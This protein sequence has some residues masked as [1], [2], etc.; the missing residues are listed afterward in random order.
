V[1]PPKKSLN[2]DVLRLFAFP[3]HLPYKQRVIITMILE[4]KA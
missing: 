1:G 4:V 2:T 3:E